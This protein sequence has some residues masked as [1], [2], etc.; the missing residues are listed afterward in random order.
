MGF[1]RKRLGVDG[2]PRYT[3]YYN[4][5][6]GV[7]RSAGSYASKKEAD[8]AWQRAE[9]KMAEGRLGDPRRGKQT[10]QQYVEEIWLPNHEM[11][12][13]TREAYTYSLYK[14]LMPEFGPMRMVDILPEHVRAWVTKMKERGIKPVTIR[15]NKIILS[16]IFSTAFD[17]QVIYIQ[18]SRGVKTPTVARK[19]RTIIT[20]E[21]FE[22]LYR[23][24]PDEDT[25]L[26]VETAIET[27][28]R[29]GELT[30]LRVS[31][32]DFATRILTVSRAAI[33]VNPKF[34]PEG[35]RF[36]AKEYPKDK[37]Y[38]RLKL[39]AQLIMKIQA[40]AVE[41][42]LGRDGLLFTD[43]QEAPALRVAPD[44][45]TL[46]FT[47]PNAAGRT[48]R[49]GT[50]SGYSNGKCKCRHCKDAYAIYRA[51]RRAAGKDC[52][53]TPR[54]RDTDTHISRHWFRKQVWI[55]A[56]IAA[57]LQ[58]H[59]RMHGLR[60]AHASWLLAGGADLQ[61]VKERLG[62]ASI[63]TTEKYLHTLPDADETALD[64]FTR[65]RARGS[66]R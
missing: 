3:A 59:V 34:H 10:F 38:R 48:Y 11:E 24:L 28:L 25:R 64:A 46:G 18:P 51:E 13:T 57:G 17:D 60:H 1:S 49:H 41:K 6:K 52:P 31:D 44:P 47:E 50:I 43:R 26:L 32:I 16:A 8:K 62:H 14:H 55:P 27:G 37:E 66:D 35:G 42:H 40:H 20:P 22:V 58:I 23:N 39:T 15:Y 54:R 45:E 21:Q 30:E 5:I 61:V 33:E 2:K 29:W 7:R 9:A 19:P 53:R 4:D 65:I 63:A 56:L 36:L 12:P